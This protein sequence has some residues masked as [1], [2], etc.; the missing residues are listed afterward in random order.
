MQPQQPQQPAPQQPTQPQLLS[1]SQF[2]PQGQYGPAV[3]AAGYAPLPQD[4][5]QQPQQG[6]APQPQYQQPAPVQSMGTAPGF[7]DPSG[8]GGGAPVKIRELLG[9]VVGIKPIRVQAGQLMPGAKAG[10]TPRDTMICEILV[11]DGGPLEYGSSQDRMNPAPPCFRVE[12]PALLKGVMI[13]NVVFV[14][15]GRRVLESAPGN[16]IPCRIIQGNSAFLPALLG[17]P[18]D[19]RPAEADQ[20]RAMLGAAYTAIAMGTFVNP[21]P[22]EING[23]PRPRPGAAQPQ[24]AQ[25]PPQPAYPPAPQ[26]QVVY[27]SQQPMQQQYAPA[28]Q[29]ASI[30]APV[31]WDPNIWNSLSDADKA[32]FA[33]QS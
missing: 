13:N 22:I 20:A 1:W 7:S 9:R 24:Q 10:E 18:N 19:P 27:P 15:E 25:Y 33:P 32:R 26:G 6:Y 11:L 2:A 30:A 5:G 14:D 3:A 21:T 16:V 23:G 8:G 28:Q 29:Q 17:G 31:G 4:Y 12:T